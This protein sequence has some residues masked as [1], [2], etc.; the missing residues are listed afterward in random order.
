MTA[1]GERLAG[2][3]PAWRRWG[4]YL[5]ERAWGTVRE[6]YSPDGSAWTSF[7]HDH[8]RSRAYR[9][10]EDGLAGISD[11]HQHLCLALALWN[12]RD[13]ILKERLFGLA[14]PEGNHGEDVKESY[15]YL[16]AT[17]TASYLCMLYR[18]PQAEY[19]YGGLVEENARRT[20]DDPEYELIDTGIFDGDR[21]FDILVEYAKAD[22]GDILL[23][24][25]AVNRGPAPALLHLLP[26][27]WFRNTWSWGRDDRRPALTEPTPGPAGVRV[28]HARHWRLGQLELSCEDAEALLF[29][30]NETNFP[31]L[32]GVP[33]ETRWVKDA[34]HDY[35]VHGQRD[36]VSPHRNGTRAAAHYCRM[37]PGRG[38][39]AI[40]LR[41]RPAGGAGA[42]AFADFDT[43]LA[44]RRQEADEFYE[45]LQAWAPAVPDAEGDDLRRIQRQAFAGLLWS[46]QSYHF[47]VA[48]WLDGD[49][50]Q[51]E[52]P[53]GRRRGRNH[54]WRHLNAGDVISMP[55]KWEYPWFAAWDLAFHCVA[56]ALVDPEFA[57]EQLVLLGRE[58]YQHPSGQMPAYEWAFDDVNPPVQAWA[59]WRLYTIDRHRT[60]RADLAFLERVF[61]R[62]LLTFTWWVNR[63]D[64]DGR[65]V[66]EGGFLGFD[67]ISVF[68]RSAP[69]PT[70]GRLEQ[71]DATSW[72]SMFSLNM[73]TIALELATRDR[74][75]E[76]I[77]TKFF[78]HFLYIASAMQNAA[79]GEQAL[80]DEGDGFF[81]D[82]L[83][84]P[85]GR[86]MPLR[87]RSMVGLIPLFAVETVEPALL[88]ELPAFRD[89]LEWFLTHRPDLAGLVSRWHEPGVG[90]R[91]LVALVRG[92]RMKCLL[93]RAL[94][95]A[96]FLGDHG[97]R[98][99]SK[100]H[101][102][103]PYRLR[104][105]HTEH[106]VAYEPAESRSGL[107]GG[108]SNWRGPIW[109][110]LNYLL[111][112]SLQK[113]HHYYGDDFT[114]ECPAGSGRYL[115]LEGVA[116]ELAGR[117][118]RLF[119][120]GG[121]GRRPVFGARERFQRD[122]HWRD[123]LLFHEY[124]HG[125]TGAGLGASHQTGW[126]ALIAKLIQQEGE[127][128]A[129]A[130]PRARTAAAISELGLTRPRPAPRPE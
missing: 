18:Y 6:D 104:L 103:E 123:H 52:P 39:T 40:R 53:A 66:F 101:A 54:R 55:D 130:S 75:Y 48:Q 111:I 96:E 36:A 100:A 86:A 125:D 45:A 76:D 41:L 22:P 80:W 97:V 15:H 105:D 127:R 74:V 126:T 64:A 99:L 27:L 94:D 77:A 7:P 114:V 29:T 23:R 35:I 43:I 19:P 32:F 20:R 98:S 91:R 92:H 9:W 128:H 78:E 124:F 85:D 70:G 12:G 25:T 102:A 69:L 49:P 62:L 30:G 68:D 119:L 16:D 3:A 117:L 118:V 112:E 89:R 26:T 107:F 58:W 73:M 5:G 116:D 121:D 56:L 115:T 17:P 47:D 72:M 67:N 83:R 84:L 57:K 129:A 71:S 61:H 28:I 42:P 88:E 46:R 120:R 59:A 4:P 34:F 37:I 90:D 79:G 2:D 106:V 10:G 82:V 21:Y 33:A 38:T 110:P 93:R 8:A 122:P 95:P 87:L 13:P 108:N 65:N 113:F 11:D 60:G 81:Y 31:R 14:G 24:V 63:K 51:P 1:E 109:F 44:H 50:G